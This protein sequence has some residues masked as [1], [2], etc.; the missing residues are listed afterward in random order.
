M[1]LN[2]PVRIDP[3]PFLAA[4]RDEIAATLPEPLAPLAG[5]IGHSR[6]I[7]AWPDDWDDE[8]SPGY[9]ERVWLRAV[10]FLLSNAV[11]L[12]NDRG[13][14]IPPPDIDPGAYGSIALDWRSGPRQLLLDIPVDEHAPATFYGDDG[15][16]GHVVKGSLDLADDNSWLMLWLASA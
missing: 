1:A 3:T 9:D 10:G 2:T 5:A 8:G 7:L 11:Q 13:L 6:R 4:S 12:W 16:F 15:N 14:A